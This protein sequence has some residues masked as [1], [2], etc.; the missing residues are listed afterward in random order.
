MYSNKLHSI[1][2]ALIGV[3]Y[4]TLIT[5]APSIQFPNMFWKLDR[6]RLLE[7][8]ML[9]FVFLEA[10]SI[11]F[12]KEKF[13]PI[14]KP[15]RLSLLILL[16]FAGFSTSLAF[17]P[18]H[19]IVEVS[20]FIGLG[21][22]AL[23]IAQWYQQD[24]TKCLTRLTYILWASTI[25]YLLA[26]YTGYLSATIVKKPLNWPD[27]FT[28]FNNIRSFNQYQLWGLAFLTLPL[29][30]LDLKKSTRLILH[31]ALIA[32]WVLLYYSASRGVLIAWLGAIIIT[33]I[34]YRQAAWSFI[35]MQASHMALGLLCF[36]ILFKVIPETNQSTL[37][38]L[39]IVRSTTSGRIALWE[40]AIAM[41]KAFP[42]FGA[43]PMHFA[44]Y[45]KTNA[46]P[47][48]SI[49]QL[50]SEWGI[51]ATLIMLFIVLYTLFHWMKKF[52]FSRLQK[53]T[54]LQKNLSVILFFT[55]LANCAYSFVDGVIVMPISQVLM[56]T[57][58][59]VMLGQYANENKEELPYTARI[60]PLIAVLMLITLLW[61]NYPEVKQGLS[62]DPKYFSMEHTA[63]GPRF[64]RETKVIE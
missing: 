3:T 55:I 12:S 33:G 54:A 51:P 32:W 63:I 62:G 37:K 39:D 58:I 40:Q 6:Q 11:K 48:N 1:L 36:H 23:V 61:S 46:H 59:G 29:F 57:M 17:S 41:I 14:N 18:R 8:T 19:A 21:F 20:T 56:F 45:N 22:L 24:Y 31:T 47:H 16:V 2:L 13:M 42:I 34:V 7:L 30:W 28:G 4:I 53:E 27:P 25:L 52:N 10:I 26:F 43:G 5:A 9:A 35:K 38:T 44:W 64:W 15:V 50:A 60:R 49:L